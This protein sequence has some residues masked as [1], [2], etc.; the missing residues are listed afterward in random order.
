MEVT[1]NTVQDAYI[2]ISW[3]YLPFIGARIAALEQSL[4]LSLGNPP[5]GWLQAAVHLLT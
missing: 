4:E 3:G 1:K 2:P 5:L